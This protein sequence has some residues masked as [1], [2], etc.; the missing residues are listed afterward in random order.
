MSFVFE[1]DMEKELR[2]INSSRRALIEDTGAL[3]LDLEPSRTL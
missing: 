3:E 2:A 1:T